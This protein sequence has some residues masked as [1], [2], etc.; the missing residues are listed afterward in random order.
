MKAVFLDRDGVICRHSPDYIKSWEEFEFIPGSLD[1]LKGLATLELP[2]IVISNQSCIGRGL[3]TRGAVD[4]INRNMVET[5]RKY[6]GRIDEAFIC[7]HRPDEGC[8]CRK[9]GTGML[10]EAAM[11]FDIDLSGSWVVGDNKTDI[12]MGRKVG[13]GTILVRTGLGESFITEAKSIVPPPLIARDIREAVNIIIR[14]AKND[15]EVMK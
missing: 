9:P 2:V 5:V 13:C 1:A 11:K 15:Q 3:V 4:D 8:S 12:H 6:G 10:R 14:V 7:P